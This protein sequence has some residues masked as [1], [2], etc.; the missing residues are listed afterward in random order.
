MGYDRIFTR[1]TGYIAGITY[2]AQLAHTY[3][4]ETW[5]NN[6]GAMAAT[7]TYANTVLAAGYIAVISTSGR[8]GFTMPTGVPGGKYDLILRQQAGGSP[9]STDNI[10]EVVHGRVQNDG[11]WLKT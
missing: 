5:D 4:G 7:P 6:A 3:S 10:L 8:L 2:Y 9:A 11:K 1:A